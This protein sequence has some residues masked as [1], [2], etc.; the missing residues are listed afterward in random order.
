M[1]V[2]LDSISRILLFSMWL[3]VIN[4]GKF[5]SMYT[6]CGFYVIFTVLVAFNIVFNHSNE[7]QSG[8]YWIGKM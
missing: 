8:K 4:E 6:L 2:I 7:F 5:S 1:K 3:Y